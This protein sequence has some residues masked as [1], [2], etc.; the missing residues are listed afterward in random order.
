MSEFSALDAAHLHCRSLERA[1]V[2]LRRDGLG[3]IAEWGGRLAAALHAGNRL[4]VA[5]NGGSAA[6]AQHLTAELVG[7]YQRERP[8]YSAIALHAET[9]A[10][11]AI[12]NDY[13]FEHVYARQV[14][15]HGRPGDILLLLST[16]GRSANLITAAV[17]GRAAG[18]R[19]WALTGPG[20]NPL[21]EAA[22][23]WLSVAGET[24]ATVQEAHLVAVHLLCEAFDAAVAEP[25]RAVVGHAAPSVLRADGSVS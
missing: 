18:L 7:R 24:T 5:G 1:I 21:A 12:G 10:M 17:A 20:P 14:T 2:R 6:Q 15:A 3:R 8:A 25:A 16:S 4:L 11:T 13:G 22:H 9:S 23:D 19:V